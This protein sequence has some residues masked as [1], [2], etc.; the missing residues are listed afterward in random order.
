MSQKNGFPLQTNANTNPDL[1]M[2][3]LV[4][5]EEERVEGILDL[6][7]ISLVNALPV[8][9]SQ[10]EV[11]V[12]GSGD[13]K[14]DNYLVNEGYTVYST[15]ML[16]G[17]G[18]G[19]FGREKYSDNINYSNA[20]IFD[21]DSFPVK[22]C[23]TVI[24]SEVLEH[25]PDWQN[26]LR[27]LLCLAKKRVIIT[28][29]HHRSYDV[30]GPPPAGHC[31]YWT[32]LGDDCYK[33]LGSKEDVPFNSISTF[34]Q[35]LWPHQVSISKIVTKPEDFLYASRDYL[36]IIDLLQLSDTQRS[37]GETYRLF[38]PEVYDNDCY[39]IIRS[40][41]FSRVNPGYPPAKVGPPLPY[42]TTGVVLVI[43]NFP[44]FT[45]VNKHSRVYLNQ[46][47]KEMNLHQL[48]VQ[49][50]QN[51]LLTD[52][53]PS[54]LYNALQLQPIFK[55]RLRAI[56]CLGGGVLSEEQLESFPGHIK[57]ICCD[58]TSKNVEKLGEKRHLFDGIFDLSKT[59]WDEIAKRL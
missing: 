26:A 5:P 39:K 18:H 50:L 44:S 42:Q 19:D 20:D 4:Y 13:C 14:L 10:K 57:K 46:I 29:P 52:I 32:D 22:K 8:W 28:V 23:E 58:L 3:Q 11:L 24:C 9:K 41:Y 27:N 38:C 33:G 48:K 36:I 59:S 53:D 25:I 1:N 21:L 55:D 34:T 49:P 2:S 51:G 45:G 31:N 47:E 40:D 16:D 35:F 17:P 6:R 54:N 30:P 56:I 43:H 37:I 15:D 12:V 7:Q